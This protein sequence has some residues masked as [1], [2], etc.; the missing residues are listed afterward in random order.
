MRLGARHTT[1]WLRRN[2]TIYGAWAAL[3]CVALITAFFMLDRRFPLRTSSLTPPPAV[4]VT[5]AGGEPL[6]VFL[7]KDGRRRHP[8]ALKDVS[9]TLQ[10]VLRFSEDR[11]FAWHPG[12]NPLA[13]LRAGWSNLRAWR[14]V[15]GGSTITMQLARLAAPQARTLAAKAEECFRAVQLER[16]FTKDEI[17][18]LYLNN[19]PYG[20]NVVGVEAACRVYFGKAA[21]ALSLGEAALL[22][23]LPRAP[24]GYDPVRHPERA[25]QARNRLLDALGEA[26]VFPSDEVAMAKTQALPTRLF[27]TPMEAPHASRMAHR[28]SQGSGAG[29][30]VE[31]TLDLAM[32]R[33]ALRVMQRRL[34][35]L[36]REGL[37]NAAVVVMDVES[38]AV[39]AL[40]GTDDF[41]DAH[42]H[43][44]INAA[45]AKRSPGSTLKPFLYGLA[46]DQGWLVPESMVLDIPTDYA[47]YLARNYDETY[48]GRVTVREALAQ[49]LN[50]PAVRVLARAKVGH[51][52]DLLQRGGLRLR[53]GPDHYGLPLALGACDAS[54]VEL[55][56]LYAALAGEGLY[57][58]PRLLANQP[59]GPPQRILS[60]EAAHLVR[61]ILEEVPRRDLPDAWS[62]TRDAPATAWKTGTSFGHRDAWAIGVTRQFAIGVWVGNLDGRA[63]RGVSGARVAGPL[64]FDVIRAVETPGARL[65][66]PDNLALEDVRVCSES[67]LRPSPWTPETMVV[68]G[69]HGRTRLP[70]S[71]LHRRIFV[72]DATGL[73]LEGEC[74]ARIRRPARPMLVTTPP[75]PLA[76]WMRREGLAP[77]ATL[78]PLSP[79]CPQKPAQGGPAII[80]PSARTPYALRP[81][82]PLA[83]QK[84]PLT[85][86]A[87]PDVTTLY[88]FVDGRLVATGPPTV[89]Q[90]LEADSG[91]YRV[92]AQ[93]D[94]GRRDAVTLT[95]E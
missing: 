23:V 71:D 9:P 44:P 92:V 41:F 21:R 32:Q 81:G 52:Y 88:W 8:V 24:Q 37:E 87:G 53:H 13:I 59:A 91:A 82:A 94:L 69:I 1:Q 66:T 42:H 26:G 46:F 2:G 34:P 60:R 75:A 79:E 12:V 36:R 72:D 95:V 48:R 85:A 10:R 65:P 3:V 39:Q 31:T 83:F 25:R 89:T 17:F 61:T 93:D 19:T 67:R 63:V 51:F 49:S 38:R 20:G 47:G 73:R 11:Y 57:R 64:L 58:R 76:A 54:L 40:V 6:R 14:V 22:A 70:V 43:G 80:S 35:A 28:A 18:E 27:P 30:R 33:Q 7:P 45:L 16:R 55:T 78:P 15:S 86:R 68:T 5:A 90:F 74:L 84:I 4:M 62:L 56:A 29:W 77:P 50:A